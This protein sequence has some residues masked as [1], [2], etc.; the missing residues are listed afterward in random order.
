MAI[1]SSF[2]TQSFHSLVPCYYWQHGT[3]DAR[4]ACVPRISDSLSSALLL[5]PRNSKRKLFRYKGCKCKNCEL[6]ASEVVWLLDISIGRGKGFLNLSSSVLPPLHII[7]YNRRMSGEMQEESIFHNQPVN[8]WSIPTFSFSFQC[9]VVV[10]VF[11]IR[12]TEKFFLQFYYLL[13]ST[14]GIGFFTYYILLDLSSCS[15]NEL[16]ILNIYFN[17]VVFFS[18]FYEE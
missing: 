10:V 12:A 2:S 7:R 5:F 15:W 17:S 18:F 9:V 8:K 1:H 14:M 4:L 3:L 13:I 11:A 16:W 6:H